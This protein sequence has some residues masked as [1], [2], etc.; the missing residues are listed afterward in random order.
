[1][2]SSI[3]PKI[4]EENNNICCGPLTVI[5]NNSISNSCFASGLKCADVT[6]VHKAEETTNKRNYRNV[7]LLPVVS[8]NFE[9]MMERQIFDYVEKFLSPFLCGYRKGYSAQ[10]AFEKWRF[11]LDNGRYGG[12]VLMDLSKAFDTLD[13]DLLIAKLHAYGFGRDAFRFIKSFLSGRW[14]RLKVNT[15]Y[16]TWAELLKGVR[17]QFW[18][19]LC[20]ICTLTISFS[21][22]NQTFATMQMIWYSSCGRYEP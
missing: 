22:L 2:S 19:H 13:H 15:S 16:S 12:G 3:P 6:H 10:Q 5:F 14:Q 17:G 4:L 21:L 20:I 11:S 8:K 9:R 7:S 18:D 1:M